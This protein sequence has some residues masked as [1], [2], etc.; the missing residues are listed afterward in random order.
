MKTRNIL[1]LVITILLI[2]AVA[3]FGMTGFGIGIYR[4][5][6]LYKQ[7]NL[8]LDL[9]GG[10]YAVYEADQEDFD[11]VEYNAKIATT[12]SVLR[13]RL[14]E[15]GYTEATVVQQGADRIR[16]EV[17]INET[18]ETQ[19]PSE[20][21]AF[22]SET[23]LLEFLNA[24]GET[25]LTGAKVE[26]AAVYVTGDDDEPVVKV[27]FNS[28]GAALFGEMTTTAY[29]NGETISI[30]LDGET[31]TTANVKTPITTGE[32]YISGGDNDPF[33][34]E[35]ASDLA[36]QIESGALPLVINEIENRS[37]SASLGEEA[38][39]KSLFAGLT[40]IGLLFLFMLVYYRLPGVVACIALSIYMFIMLLLLAAIPAIQLTLPGIAGIILGIGMAVDSNVIIFERFKEELRSG[41]TLRASLNAGFS[42]AMRT[43]IDSNITTVM[44]AIVI[45]FFGV[46]TV[47][48]FGYT[49][50][51]SIV[52][53]MFT[54]IVVTKS[55][56]KVVMNFNV[57]NI[58]LYTV[59][60]PTAELAA[61][62]GH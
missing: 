22:I 39:S 52:T 40:G 2:G 33:T 19:D 10:V 45:A 41:K 34:L 53:S 30:K 17:P 9:T 28:E 24:D 50:V 60:P 49:L 18:S 26:Q 38:L 44:A 54:A 58:K 23:G 6:P 11:T 20:I 7:V 25:I 14:D 8:G 61:K 21:L 12:I 3:Y 46:G 43:I 29:E 42:K 56:L 47:K 31:I 1:T 62:G 51:I 37:I 4:V 55:L 5:D 13:N 36:I 32:G 35:E 15:K 59:K 48:S 57:K 27:T 16:V